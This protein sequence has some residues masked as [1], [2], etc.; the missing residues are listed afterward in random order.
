MILQACNTRHFIHALTIDVT[1]GLDQPS[2]NITEGGSP[3][4]ICAIL[5]GQADREVLVT[6]TTVPV[7]A[8]GT[9]SCFSL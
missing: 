7:S 1:V 8:Q 3:L 4:S 5:S 6:I 2:Y 9:A